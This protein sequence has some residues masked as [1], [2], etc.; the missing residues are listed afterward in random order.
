L[1]TTLSFTLVGLLVALQAR[2][3]VGSGVAML[4]ALVIGQCAQL[5]AHWIRIALRVSGSWIA[6]AG[7][8][9]LGLLARGA[10]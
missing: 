3:G 4:T 7:L 10:F 6:A 2:L 8:L 9:M 5:R 1:L